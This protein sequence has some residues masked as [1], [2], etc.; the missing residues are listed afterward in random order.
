[1]LAIPIFIA[2]VFFN[3]K[4]NNFNDVFM[5][6][7]ITIFFIALMPYL[8]ILLLYKSGRISDLQIQKRKE[9]LYPLLVINLSVIAGFC[10]L[11]ATS[12]AK[13]LLT[14]YSIYLVSLP[15]IS[16]ITFFWKIS[17]H[18]SYITLF[19]IIYLIVFGKWA[20]AT[21]VL[22]PLVGWSRIKLKKHTLAQVVAGISITAFAALSVLYF[23]GYLNSGYWAVNEILDLFKNTSVYLSII[24]PG[25]G[26]ILLFLLLYMI[27]GIYLRRKQSEKHY[28][29]N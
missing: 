1:V 18:S 14:V 5:N 22:I 27:L 19:S 28:L 16:L 6:F 20:V 17:F 11:L 8:F 26:I 2:V 12:P 23:T 4:N 25:F 24:L 21:V 13:L 7:L 29:N 3:N 10:V 9:R 15:V